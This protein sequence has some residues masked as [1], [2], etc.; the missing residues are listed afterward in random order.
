M[1]S[2]VCRSRGAKGGQPL[3]YLGNSFLCLPLAGQRPTSQDRTQRHKECKP[4]FSRDGDQRL[5]L[6]LSCLSFL[7]KLMEPG[8]NESDIRHTVG[9]REPLSQGKRLAAP[10]QSLVRIT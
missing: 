8:G 3:A 4:L 2:R 7:P 9:V 6:L 5:S 10:L 1:R